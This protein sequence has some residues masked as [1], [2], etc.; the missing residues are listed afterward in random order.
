[1]TQI[2]IKSKKI[3]LLGAFL[4]LCDFIQAKT[5]YNLL[6]TGKYYAS[7]TVN[8]CESQRAPVT[9]TITNPAAP[10][11][12]STQ[13]FCAS[14]YPTV[15]QLTA[16]GTSIKWYTTASGGTAVSNNAALTSGTYFA[17][18]TI[19][20]CEGS[21]RVQVNVTVNN[22]PAPSASATQIF[23][24]IDNPTLANL[25]ISG[26]NIFY[27]NYANSTTP[28][29]TNSTLSAGTYYVAS[30]QN[31][32]ESN[33]IEIYNSIGQLILVKECNS[34]QVNLQLS[35][36]VTEFYFAKVITEKGEKTVKFITH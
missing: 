15:A 11:A 22:T 27:F 2:G 30:L 1:M 14:S 9:L 17:S 35:H 4:I 21:G 8:G 5:T 29:D 6:I 19:N 16:T 36:L 23:C 26:T 28:L 34:S 24:E 25:T 31:N 3:M 10:S 20:S 18:Q 33:R 12:N 32:C 7:Q 13:T